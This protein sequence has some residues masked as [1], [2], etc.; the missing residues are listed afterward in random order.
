AVGDVPVAHHQL[1]RAL[2]VVLDL[3]VIGSDEPALLGR[4]FRFKKGGPD[5]HDDAFGFSLVGGGVQLAGHADIACSRSS[6]MSSGSSRPTDSRTQLWSSPICARSSSVRERW[7]V[8]AGWVISVFESPRLLEMS[9]RP[10]LLSIEN[11]ALRPP[12]SDSAT[13]EPPP[14]G[15]CAAWML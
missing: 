11:A 4:A 12:F 6:T 9:M 2:R 1:Q 5:A 7:V 10:R 3:D 8:V 13:S 14:S 15:I